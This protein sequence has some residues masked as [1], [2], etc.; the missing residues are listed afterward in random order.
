VYAFLAQLA[1]VQARPLLEKLPKG[2]FRHMMAARL[3]EIAKVDVS[4]LG[5]L[6]DETVAITGFVSNSAG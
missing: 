1:V 6:D 3:A 4:A 5:G 2:V